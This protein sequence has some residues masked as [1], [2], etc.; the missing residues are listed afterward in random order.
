[1]SIKKIDQAGLDR[2]VGALIDQTPVYG[3]QAKQDRFAFGALSS[4]DSLR[5]DYDVS[6]L[7]PKKY[8]QPQRE[9]M[10]TFTTDGKFESVLEEDPFVLFG[11]HPYDYEAIRQMDDIFSMNNADKHYLARRQAATIVVSDVQTAS[12]NVFATSMGNATAENMEGWDV[13]LTQV[14]G[15]YL[16]ETGTSKGEEAIAAIADAPDATDEDLA[17]RSKVWDEARGLQQKHELKMK[18]EEIPE[19]LDKSYDH[20]VWAEKAQL[21]YSCGSCNLVCPTCYCFDVKDEWNWDMESGER[22]REWDGCMLTKF[23]RVAGNH[24]FRERETDRY[25]HRY[26]RK[27]KFVYDM[28]GAIS[29]VGCGRCITACTANIANPVEVFNRLLEEK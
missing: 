4:P 27:G 20:P 6:I 15:A 23:A 7:P 2:W 14:N 9:T 28:I 3:V 8:F 1:M 21:C 19:L 17:A 11:V 10:M 24:N 25:R 18:P 29:C 5:L 26:L 13:L 16:V 12:K 22:V